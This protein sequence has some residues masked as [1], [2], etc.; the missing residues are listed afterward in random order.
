MSLLFPLLIFNFKTL[1]FDPFLP[2]PLELARPTLLVP[3]VSMLDFLSLL[4]PLTCDYPD[5]LESTPLP[6]ELVAI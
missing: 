5:L 6:T 4:V 1:S 3:S 2:V